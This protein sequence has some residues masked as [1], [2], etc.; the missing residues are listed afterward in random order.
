V[1]TVLAALLAVGAPP[2]AARAAEPGGAA[3]PAALAVA[4]EPAG[5]NVFVDGQFQGTTPVEV[6][7]LAPG[8]H[9]VRLVK[10]GYLENSRLVSVA[11]GQPGRVQ[12]QLTPRPALQVEPGT[13]QGGGGG[14]SKKWLWIG[15][16][17]VAVGAGAFLLLKGG[18]KPP[19]PGT[20]TAS[21]T[22]ALMAVTT[23]SFTASGASD[24]DGDPLTYTWDFGDGATGSGQTATHVYN[25]AGTFTARLTVSD[26]K[27]NATASA[28]AVTVRNVNG[29]WRTLIVQSQ[30]TFGLAQTGAN[31]TGS[32][33]YIYGN[34]NC[35]S[36]G[37]RIESASVSSPLHM[38]ISVAVPT[39]C[40]GSNYGI[41]IY[42]FSCDFDPSIQTCSGSVVQ[43]S[44]RY[45]ITMKR[46]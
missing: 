39:V 38:A 11:S 37:E 9:R 45:S 8:D 29:T 23:V 26:G 16:G 3:V 12:V 44:N 14:G 5:A 7:R 42:A 1:A 35:S 27:A 46:D 6:A 33:D 34:T 4:S 22:T 41:Y 32:V 13:E 24:P 19:V 2:V 43:G 15:L 20:A 17:A 18:N 28:S 30:I 10:D 40:Y 36:N 21:T 31:V 25:T